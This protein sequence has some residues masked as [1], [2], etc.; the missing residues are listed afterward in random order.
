MKKLVWIFVIVIA[1][2]IVSAIPQTFNIHGKLADSGG[3]ALSGTYN[4]N[5]TIYDAWTS[6]N[7]LWSDNYSVTT[8]S[9][10]IYNI[11]LTDIDLSFSAQYYLGVKVEDD[12]EMEPRINLTSTPYTFRANVSDN[13]NTANNYQMQNLTLGQKITFAFNEVIDNIVDGFIRITGGLNVTGNVISGGNV[14][15]NYYFGSG[16]YLTGIPGADPNWN[17]SYADTKY[18]NL[19]GGN[20]NQNINIG[21]YNLTTTG[22]GTFGAGGIKILESGATP[23]KY[24]TL[25][26]ADLTTADRTFTFPNSGGTIV[27]GSGTGLQIALWS[28]ANTLSSSP[29]FTF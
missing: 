23:T 20:A 27:T 21:S 2:G 11:I 16:Q 18:L 13:L 9:D 12:A 4:M 6:G 3:N 24:I 8:D 7:A 25:K 29:E 28:G 22:T 26:S 17:E 5:F 1:M 10:G 19:S 14:T 15:A